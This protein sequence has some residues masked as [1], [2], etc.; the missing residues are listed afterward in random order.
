MNN[1]TIQ[2]GWQCPQ[3]SRIYSP[4]THMCYYCSPN[5][6]TKTSTAPLRDSQIY[7]DLVSDGGLDPR[8]KYD[9]KN[10]PETKND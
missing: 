3:C 6:T 7:S 1:M 5:I 8:N 9:Q 10:F 4:L 2:Q